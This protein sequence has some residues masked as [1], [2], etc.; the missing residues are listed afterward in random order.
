[1][2]ETIDATFYFYLAGNLVIYAI[3]C[4][5]QYLRL[6]EDKLNEELLRKE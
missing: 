4:I 6:R 3:G 1:V 5:W 2:I